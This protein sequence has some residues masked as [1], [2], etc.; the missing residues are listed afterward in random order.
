MKDQFFSK[1][2]SYKFWILILM[3]TAA[4]AF[5]NCSGKVNFST[6]G[7]NGNAPPDLQS[8]T[9]G[10]ENSVNKASLSNHLEGQIYG[11]C[12][13][14]LDG[15]FN[16]LH[17]GELNS[18]GTKLANVP[19]GVGGATWPVTLCPHSG[20]GGGVPVKCADGFKAVANELVQ[21]DCSVSESADMCK[22]Y[23]ITYNCI[24]TSAD[25]STASTSGSSSSSGASGS[26]A[27]AA[28][29]L[30]WVH[31]NVTTCIG[32]TPPPAAIGTA[33]SPSGATASNACGTATC[34]MAK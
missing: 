27:V 32:P 21:M 20:S 24:K 19:A 13:L 34:Q 33:C 3:A 4:V 10:S 17:N 23:W 30:K 8:L 7:T 16:I 29:S 6:E 11:H 5:Q 28:E 14:Q 31:T 22:T 12:S 26:S 18:S 25:R 15:N 9:L 2:K 1:T